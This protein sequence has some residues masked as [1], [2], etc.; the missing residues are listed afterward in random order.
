MCSSIDNKMFSKYD[1]F[2]EKIV[3][4]L[5]SC[6][7]LIT[8]HRKFSL[9]QIVAS[10]KSFYNFETSVLLSFTQY[11]ISVPTY[12]QMPTG[13]LMNLFHKTWS[14]CTVFL[15]VLLNFLVCHKFCR[16][17]AIFLVAGQALI[18]VLFFWSYLTDSKSR[19]W[20]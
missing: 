20:Y 3:N 8:S 10:R 5:H 14:L 7:R 13:Y 15:Q 19:P 2:G 17:I 1:E 12:V 11:C 16:S 18:S 6:P 9:C 4:A